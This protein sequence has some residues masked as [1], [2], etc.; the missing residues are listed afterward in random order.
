MNTKKLIILFLA[1]SLTFANMHAKQNEKT[2]LSKANN[3]YYTQ[4]KKEESF[5]IYKEASDTGNMMAKA[6]VAMMYYFGIG[7]KKNNYLA[8]N[9]F[10]S[11]VP[12]VEFEA[13]K[14]NPFAQYLYG[15]YRDNGFGFRGIKEPQEAKKWYKKAAKN[16]N[17]TA[18]DILDRSGK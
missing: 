3:L 12:F 1:I 10:L 6:Q 7:V 18:Q 8:E 2:L 5:K 15:Y 17:K 14:G 4:G 9:Y 16:G 11:V 13:N